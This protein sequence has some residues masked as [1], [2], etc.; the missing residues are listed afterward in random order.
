MV[1][2]SVIIPTHRRPAFLEDAIASVLQQTY[3]QFDN[4]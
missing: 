3:T 2:V 4:D 1:E